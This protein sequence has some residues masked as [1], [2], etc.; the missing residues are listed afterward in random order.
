MSLSLFLLVGAASWL[1]LYCIEEIRIIREM[2]I[3][4]AKALAR[5]AD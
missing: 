1:T 2:R 3:R 5:R 4:E